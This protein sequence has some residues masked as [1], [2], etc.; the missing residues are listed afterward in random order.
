[1]DI[2]DSHPIFPSS[3]VFKPA[4]HASQ[5]YNPRLMRVPEDKRREKNSNMAF[6]H[7]QS[8]FD[9][10]EILVG[11]GFITKEGRTIQLSFFEAFRDERGQGFC[12]ELF[13]FLLLLSLVN[14]YL[15][16]CKVALVF[17]CFRSR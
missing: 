6:S 12:Q 9:Q 13:S 11:V 7:T 14:R 4:N 8:I 5:G 3:Q 17:F 2:R 10:W 15:S 16:F 1:M